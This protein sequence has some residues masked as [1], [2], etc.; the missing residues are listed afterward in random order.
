[1]GFFTPPSPDEPAGR[2]PVIEPLAPGRYKLQVTIS[3]DTREKLQRAR[4][5]LRHQVPDGDIA[6]VLDRA[7]TLL[8]EDLE[9]KKAAIVR[10]PRAKAEPAPRPGQKT[11]QRDSSHRALAGPPKREDR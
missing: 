10:R 2:R 7:L 8:V 3:A 9:R 4:D 1:V 6:S 5:L 11:T